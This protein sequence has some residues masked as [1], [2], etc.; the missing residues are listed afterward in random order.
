M[1]S[2]TIALAVLCV[3]LSPL[4]LQAQP[5]RPNIILVLADDLGWAD[6]ACYGA[7]LHETPHLDRL[8]RASL[9]FTHAYAPAPVCTPTRAAI[10]TGKHPARLHMTIWREAAAHPPGDRQL[11]PP[12]VRGDLAFQETTLAEA[13][14][15]QGYLTAHVGKWHLGDASGFPEAHGFEF[16]VGGNHWGAP[17]THFFPFRGEGFGEKR[18]VPGLPWG[19]PGDYLA[20]RLTDVAVDVIQR[21][22]ERPFFLNLWHYGVH[23]PIEAPADAI[24]HFAGKLT[25]ALQH[26]NAKYAAMVKNLDDN[27][28]RLLAA[29]DQAG[30]ADR[31]I[32][33]FASD[34]GGY[35]NPWSREPGVPV[36][37][38]HPLRSGK[39]SLY[40]G[41]LRVPLI[42]RAPGVTG[43]G[44][45]CDRPVVLTDLYRTLLE[46]A[47][48]APALDAA[49]QADG[50]SIV[51]L[52][53]E[54]QSA[55]PR[56]VLYWH[57]PHYYPTNTPSSAIRRGDWKLIEYYED[58]RAE[59]YNLAADQGEAHDLTAQ[60]PD[61]VAALRTELRQWLA[62]VGAQLPARNESSNRE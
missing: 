45:T 22:G 13:L 3:A 59:L 23:T 54:P 10:L 20:D 62:E 32:L 24:A 38:N 55:A 40:E 41:G 39:G 30:I 17:A 19:K 37:S 15:A 52:L 26:Q 42:V 12:V 9:R 53:R 25:P 47:G 7:D 21:A 51:G 8:A 33:V 50:R 36:T 29:V 49:Q 44:T 61:Q 28:G 2:G 6:L 16:H 31:T 58:D 46:L 35:V 4:M 34:N 57:Y 27:V 48:G 11:L 18:Y 43:A 1:R 60:Q 56:E 5:N 14:A